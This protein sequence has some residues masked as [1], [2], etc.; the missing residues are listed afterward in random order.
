MSIRM[1][2]AERKAD[3]LN[4]A[5]EASRRIGYSKVRQKDIAEQANCG[6][7]TVSLYFK[8][9]AQMRRAV[10]RA[11]IE[12]RILPIIAEGLAIRDTQAQKAPEELKKAALKALQA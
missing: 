7:G 5:V 6:F 4:A 3:I 2:P 10:M 11:A 12:R 8:T 9:M 1:K